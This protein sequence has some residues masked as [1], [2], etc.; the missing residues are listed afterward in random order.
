M[1][2]FVFEWVNDPSHFLFMGALY[3]VL[4]IL[5]VIVNFCGIRA[6]LDWLCTKDQ[7]HGHGDH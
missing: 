1:F 7:G 4:G 6:T 3:A 5:F 2:P